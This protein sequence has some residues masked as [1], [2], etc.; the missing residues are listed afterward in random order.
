[1]RQELLQ[2]PDLL[3]R[4]IAGAIVDTRDRGSSISL[5][6]VSQ[7]IVFDAWRGSRLDNHLIQLRFH[8]K[9]LRRLMMDLLVQLTLIIV[10]PPCSKSLRFSR[11]CAAL[12]RHDLALKLVD[13]AE[14]VGDAPRLDNPVCLEAH[15]VNGR[16]S[17]RPVG[18]MQ[19]G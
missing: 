15:S 7:L 12:S 17:H 1:M 3:Y 2:V 18:R 13:C 9:I 14:Q 11:I 4:Y 16:Q 8:L 19:S 6:Q 5:A 10:L